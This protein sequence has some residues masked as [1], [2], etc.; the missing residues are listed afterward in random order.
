MSTPVA[1]LYANPQRIKVWGRSLVQLY[2]EEA[3]LI[4]I[5]F[6][7][8]EAN[9]LVV[10]CGGGREALA[11]HQ[12]GYRHISGL[13]CTPELLA[14]AEERNAEGGC[15]INFVLGWAEDMPFADQQFE[16]VL[17]F[18]NVYGHI[19]PRA[20]RQ[21]AMAEARRVLKPGGM[22]L[23][24]ATSIYHSY[25]HCLW[26]MAGGV[27]HTLY[28][29]WRMERGDKLFKDSRELKWASAADRPRSHWFRPGE[30]RREI[31]AAGL[32]IVQATTNE[33]VL[34]D[35]RAPSTRY[36]GQGRLVF[37]ARR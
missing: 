30:L 10:G 34:R 3:L 20:V 16:A 28:N 6:P 8:Q 22:V 26:I 37:L 7:D 13:D 4:Q 23:V 14:I 5:Y 33:A 36:R 17:M 9:I 21:N 18:E 27:F 15:G 31:T 29:P 32:T 1:K 12:L 25:L 24:E 11:L 2:E 19:T 35:P